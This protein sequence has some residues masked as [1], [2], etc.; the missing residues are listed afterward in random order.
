MIYVERVESGNKYIKK[1]PLKIL[2]RNG[3]LS[4]FLGYVPDPK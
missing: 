3:I 4:V 1:G 2:S